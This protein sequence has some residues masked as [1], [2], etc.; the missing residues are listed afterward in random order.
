[1]QK[2]TDIIKFIDKHKSNIIH[3]ICENYEFSISMSDG[4]SLVILSFSMI[5]ISKNDIVWN[6]FENDRS[7]YFLFFL[8]NFEIL[9]YIRVSFYGR[10]ISSSKAKTK[11]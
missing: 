8:S 2:T 7:H 6:G 4:E 11:Y 3:D 1:M 5:R 9:K 10:I